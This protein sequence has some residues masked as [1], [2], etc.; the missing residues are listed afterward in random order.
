LLGYKLAD[1]KIETDAVMALV[2][3]VKMATRTIYGEG[4]ALPFDYFGAGNL[5]YRGTQGVSSEPEAPQPV[6][7]DRA[8]RLDSLATATV[9]PMSGL[10][11]K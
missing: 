5:P 10:F 1:R 4:K 7:D 6:I 3:A 8:L 11:R 9:V 2:I